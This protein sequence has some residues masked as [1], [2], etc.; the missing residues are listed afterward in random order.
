MVDDFWVKYVGQENFD[1]LLN[2]LCNLYT[3][4]V[5]PKRKIFLWLTLTW[6]YVNGHVDI[7]MP[8][9][10][11]KN[12][13]RFEHIAQ[14]CAQHSPYEW[15]IPKYE[16]KTQYAEDNESPTVSLTIKKH[17]QQVVGLLLYYALELDLTM[18]IVL[19]SIADQQS[20]PTKKL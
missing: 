8:G 15:Q 6:D 11:K 5:G 1:H 10:I 7:L 14:G 12:L 9:Y 19:S 17:I 20:N 4:T 2:A 18:I 13:T 16:Q 3:I